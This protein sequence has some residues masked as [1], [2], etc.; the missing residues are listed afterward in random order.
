[1]GFI[2]VL[3]EVSLTVITQPPTKRTGR[4]GPFLLFNGSLPAL[5]SSEWEQMHLEAEQGLVPTQVSGAVDLGHG[6]P[7]QPPPTP[8]SQR[9]P[10]S[11]MPHTVAIVSGGSS[12]SGT[13]VCKGLLCAKVGR[14]L[15]GGMEGEAGAA[16]GALQ[17]SRGSAHG[18]L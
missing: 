7:W 14:V 6:A 12:L 17:L 13:L 8:A 16:G 15:E 10:S 5:P 4:P 9:P 18:R 2:S 3:S 11:R 1:M